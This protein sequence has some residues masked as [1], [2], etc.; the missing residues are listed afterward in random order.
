MRFSGTSGAKVKPI[1]FQL[2]MKQFC[3]VLD[4][5]VCKTIYN[6]IGNAFKLFNVIFK[7]EK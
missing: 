7:I 3:V 6:D 2:I 4:H 5:I 1:T